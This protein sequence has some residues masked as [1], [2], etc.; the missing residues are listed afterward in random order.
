MQ[1]DPIASGWNPQRLIASDP[2]GSDPNVACD[3]LELRNG[4]WVRLR[5]NYD[6]ACRHWS[7]VKE[8]SD[9]FHKLPDSLQPSRVTV[10]QSLD[11]KVPR[12]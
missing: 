5:A 4:E 12:P 7:N 11:W 1:F 9:I 8:V 3:A 10:G 2:A 6:Y